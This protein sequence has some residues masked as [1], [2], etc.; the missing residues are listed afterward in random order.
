MSEN[1]TGL[2]IKI[3]RSDGTR[4][5]KSS[6]FALFCHKRGI[7][8][9]FT[10]NY[11]PQQNGVNECKNRTLVEAAC[12]M[13]TQAQFPKIFWDEAFSTT[14]YLQNRSPTATLNPKP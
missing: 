7:L 14:T 8:Q 6:D 10:A 12:C 11:S 5:Y 2:L 4:E 13:L 1:Q 3:L 9:Q